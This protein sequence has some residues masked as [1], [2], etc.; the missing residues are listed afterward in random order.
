MLAIT[1]PCFKTS[2]AIMALAWPVPCAFSATLQDVLYLMPDKKTSEI[3][4]D[5]PKLGRVL[6]AGTSGDPVWQQRKVQWSEHAGAESRTLP[7]WTLLVKAWDL[8]PQCDAD[9]VLPLLAELARDGPQWKPNAP[10]W[11][12]RATRACAR[13]SRPQNLTDQGLPPYQ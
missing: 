8:P 13:Q 10:C 3:T 4:K 2:R 5:I 7:C 11:M 12:L 1:L 6:L 9:M